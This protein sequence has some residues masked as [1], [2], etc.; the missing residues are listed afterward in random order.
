[1]KHIG[2][3]ITFTAVLWPYYLLVSILSV[4]VA[5]F[6][7]AI[8]LLTKSAIDHITGG[9]HSGHTTLTPIIVIVVLIFLSDFGQAI[10]SNIN[11]YVGDQLQV[12]LQRLLSQRYYQ[13]IVE[14]PQNYFDSELTGTIINKLNRG[15]DQLTDYVQFFTNNFLQLIITTIFSII[16]VALYSWPVALL[17]LALFPVYAWLAAR[18]SAKWQGYQKD[19]NKQVDVAS[20]RFAESVTQIK[21]VKSF[22]REIAELKTYDNLWQHIISLTKP[23]S[24]YWHGQDMLRRAVL[25]VMFLAIYAVIFIEAARGNYAIGTMVLLIQ[26]AQQTRMPLFSL[27]FYVDRTQRAIANSRDYFA[28]MDERPEIRD[29]DGAKPLKVTKG[30]IRIDQVDFRYDDLT[31]VLQGLSFTVEPDSKL[32]LVGESGQGK[33]TITNLLLRLYEV[34]NGTITID[35]QNINDV[36]QAS[37][38]QNIGVVFQEPALFSGT[39]RENIAYGKSTASMQQ[40]EK[41]AK[42]ANAHD[43]IGKF[44]HGYDTE[45]GE[46]GLKL[47]GGQKQRIAIARALLKDAPILILDEATSSLDTRSERQVQSALEHLMKG[48]STLIIAHRLSTIQQVDTIVTLQDGKVNEV[49]S[50]A[51]LAASGGIYAQLLALQHGDTEAFKKYDMVE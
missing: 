8:P 20:G 25:S 12:R 9:L 39:I 3:I 41:A 6:T 51:E 28:V 50:P 18:S 42:A 4:I 30:E 22:V 1:M 7:L 21:V 13:H 37:L 15:V 29:H 40:I 38:R 17:L 35:G 19:I 31:P 43:F 10:V 2:R 16:I 11:G 32:A 47:S 26:Y 44:P 34:D 48:R 33:T 46:R 24:R 36:Q 23:Q 27:S 5:A 14:L 45:I 49:G